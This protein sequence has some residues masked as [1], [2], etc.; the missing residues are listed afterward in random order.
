VTEIDY[1]GK[2]SGFE[3]VSK[4]VQT[5]ID[6]LSVL[7]RQDLEARNTPQ[8]RIY[9]GS[10]RDAA[11]RVV[12]ELSYVINNPETGEE[13]EYSVDF[14]PE[15]TSTSH[16]NLKLMVTPSLGSDPIVK[17]VQYNPWANSPQ[18]TEETLPFGGLGVFSV[19]GGSPKNARRDLSP[20]EAES[21]KNTVV[22]HLTSGVEALEAG[23]PDSAK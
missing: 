10:R 4:E 7:S 15:G 6:R 9:F 23:T 1:R 2:E 16:A 21:V 20:E 3:D 14:Q 12:T 19:G 11:G 8:S 18:G 5:L 17:K 13:T 22:A